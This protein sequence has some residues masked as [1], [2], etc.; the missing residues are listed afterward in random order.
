MTDAPTP[1]PVP[2]W[3]LFYEVVDGY[4]EKRM[5]FRGEHFR[6]ARAA[7]ERGELLLAG[8][9]T[10]PADGAVLV[11]RSPTADAAE[12]FA[13]AD[14]YVREGVVTGWRVRRWIVV[15]GEGAEI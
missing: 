5:P 7:V 13:A 8:A 14:P 4:V 11:F 12:A 2:H 3:L 9:L 1:A 6:H 10:D 15:A